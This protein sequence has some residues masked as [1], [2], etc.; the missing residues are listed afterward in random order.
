MIDLILTIIAFVTTAAV[1]AILAI[2]I[3]FLFCF[4][5]D[6]IVNWFAK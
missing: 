6:A 1:G 5:V 2:G 4:I 3:L